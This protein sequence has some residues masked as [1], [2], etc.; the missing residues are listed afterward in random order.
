MARLHYGSR[1]V[2]SVCLCDGREVIREGML[3]ERCR[4]MLIL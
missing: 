2:L 4:D 3:C 1:I